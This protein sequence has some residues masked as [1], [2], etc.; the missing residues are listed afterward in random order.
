MRRSPPS[1]NLQLRGTYDP[2]TQ[3]LLQEITLP[4]IKGLA[5]AT[6]ANV[7]SPGAIIQSLAHFIQKNRNNSRKTQYSKEKEFFDLIMASFLIVTMV[8]KCCQILEI[9]RKINHIW[10]KQA[11][12]TSW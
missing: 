12:H 8:G 9:P 2:L 3:S 6:S 4:I 7:G 1:S 10:A 11:H 5:M